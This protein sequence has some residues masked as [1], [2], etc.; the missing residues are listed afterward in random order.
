MRAS[1]AGAGGSRETSFPAFPFALAKAVALAAFIAVWF[2]AFFF[3]ARSF[4]T[5][6]AAVNPAASTKP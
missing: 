6:T 4:Y 5:I 1:V 3:A 2:S